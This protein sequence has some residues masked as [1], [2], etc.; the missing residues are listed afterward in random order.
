VR[1]RLLALAPLVAAGALGAI[2]LLDVWPSLAIVERA[3]HGAKVIA[4][5]GCLLA[6]LSYPR[7][8]LRFR[9]WGL[10]AVAFAILVLRDAVLHRELLGG[11]PPFPVE[12]V[13]LVIANASAV[14]GTWWL[15]RAWQGRAVAGDHA[16]Q[17]AMLRTAAI[18]IAVFIT[19]PSLSM[20][21]RE[22]ATGSPGA[23]VGVAAVLGDILCLSMVAPVALTALSSRQRGTSWPWTLFTASLFAWLCYDATFML[24]ALVSAGARIFWVMGEVFRVFACLS[25]FAAGLAQ[26]WLAEHEPPT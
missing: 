21:I 25:A 16:A 22:L 9:G 13:L 26:H 10:Q 4:L 7:G 11:R 24:S 5:L 18:L 12:P 23:M 19:A 1:Y 2:G 8:D 6:A 14:V 3:S 17:R 20:R 15:A